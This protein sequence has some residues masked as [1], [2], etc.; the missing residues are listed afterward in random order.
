MVV[1]SCFMVVIDRKVNIVVVNE[2]NDAKQ[3]Y[4]CLVDI[5]SANCLK[6]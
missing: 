1:L 6:V 2:V 3:V 4:L 5:G